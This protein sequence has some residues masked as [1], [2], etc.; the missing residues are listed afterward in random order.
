MV[1]ASER[2]RAVDKR[3]TEQAARLISGGQ[4]CTVDGY[5]AAHLWS[6]VPRR[7]GV[8]AVMTSRHRSRGLVRSYRSTDERR[9]SSVG[10]LTCCRWTASDRRPPVYT[11]ADYILS[12]CLGSCE[13][14]SHTFRFWFSNQ[15]KPHQSW[16]R[17]LSVLKTVKFTI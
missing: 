5:Q 17:R 9:G 2:A 12:L 1:R 15:Q 16:Q 3:V 8:S 6:I 11:L 7:R 4:A 10:R 13:V 14:P